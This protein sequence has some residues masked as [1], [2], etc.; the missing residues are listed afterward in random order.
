LNDIDA[1]F[2]ASTIAALGGL[3]TAL[4]TGLHLRF[5]A[6]QAAGSIFIDWHSG[7]NAIGSRSLKCDVR[8][9]TRRAI[10]IR[11]VIVNGPVKSFSAEIPDGQSFGSRNG[12]APV[13][14]DVRAG[15]SQALRVNLTLDPAKVKRQIYMLRYRPKW[16][17]W[18]AWNLF[19]LHA[20]PGIKFSI[21]VIIKLSA[22]S[23]RTKAFTH[24]IRLN[25]ATIMQI[26]EKAANAEA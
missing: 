25:E 24:R 13:F 4:F 20:P 8:N 6:K 10:C 17:S 21:R 15:G 9:E 5:S 3:L 19:S 23:S 14:E 18:V 26:E 12:F 11:H 2:W 22:D 7:I 1:T 16:V